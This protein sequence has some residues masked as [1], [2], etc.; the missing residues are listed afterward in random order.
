[1]RNRDKALWELNRFPGVK[2]AEPLAEV[3]VTLKNKGRE[4]N[5]VIIGLP[6]QN[7]LYNIIDKKGNTVEPP[8]NGILVTE[9]LA[10]VLD[11]KP[12]DTVY[13]ESPYI[14]EK[15]K[16]K[17][18]QVM[19]T[20]PQYVGINGYME[21]NSL[22]EL[23]GQRDITT[24]VLLAVNEKQMPELQEKYGNAQIVSNVLNRKEA[25][26]KMKELMESYS[27]S[28]L[29]L[30]LFGVI[31]SFA[32]IYNTSIISLSE[33]SRE[34]A[35]MLVI[36]MFPSEVLSVVTLEQWAIALPAMMVG[37]PLTKLL[38]VGIAYGTSSDMFTMPTDMDP[39]SFIA[40]FIITSASIIIAQK[41][42]ARKINTLKL[43]DVL[44]E[45]S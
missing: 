34:L 21:L 42:A 1:P 4:K 32:V 41:A 29:I 37:V 14:K 11:I 15:D 3:P 38:L 22:G 12:G 6:R 17:Q 33:R 44:R 36:G 18:V 16:E 45:Q 7:S 39:L 35:T 23:I 31:T 43:T 25:F 30:A 40:A 8:E 5:L 2:K 28:F 13:I 24:S 26:L 27:W 9:R 20:V 10:R 19:G